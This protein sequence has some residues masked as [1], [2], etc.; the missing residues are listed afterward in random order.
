MNYGEIKK[1]D[2]A[3]GIGVRV[4]LFVSGCRN[5]CKNCFNKET[6]D[7]SFGQPFTEETAQAI[8]EYLK[9]DYITGL[10][11]LG[12]EPLE[13]ENQPELFSLTSL[14]K[15]K[16]PNK[17]IWCFTGF[18]FEELNSENCRANTSFL[19]PLLRNIDILVDGRYNEEKKN[20]S[21]QFRGSENQ[22]IIDLPKTYS[23]G[24]ITLWSGCVR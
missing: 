16:F 6:W 9:P 20:I 24:E 15:N 14:V 2:I 22:R 8:M 13:P 1:R 21:L 23:S 12:G 4:S 19:Q 5:A 7:F 3:N 18:T 17:D 10:T 11:L